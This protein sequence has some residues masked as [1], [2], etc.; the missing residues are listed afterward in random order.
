MWAVVGQPPFALA[1]ALEWVRAEVA[2]NR[3]KAP[4][5]REAAVSFGVL[6]DDDGLTRWWTL[7]LEPS[8]VR[9]EPAPAP[10]EYEAP[11]AIVYAT[12]SELRALTRGEDA[13]GLEAEGDLEVLTA[14]GPCFDRGTSVIGVRAGR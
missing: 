3:A 9:L 14:L 2:A 13:P 1:Q 4:K 10:L 5:L 7:Y 6:D 12:A 8:E 11:L